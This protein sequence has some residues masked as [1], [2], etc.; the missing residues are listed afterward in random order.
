ML[1][2]LPKLGISGTLARHSRR[3]LIPLKSIE[4]FE[5]G[6]V[7]VVLNKSLSKRSNETSSDARQY[8]GRQRVSQSHGKDHKADRALF[9]V[10]EPEIDPRGTQQEEPHRP[11]QRE[12]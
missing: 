4:C 8:Q 1:S 5:K 6:V 10:A 11:Q 9:M 2:R 3:A 7:S 12:Q